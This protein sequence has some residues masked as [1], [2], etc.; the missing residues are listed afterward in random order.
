M[1]IIIPTEKRQHFILEGYEIY[2][3][4]R[5]N[6]SRWKK[7]SQKVSAELALEDENPIKY[8][9]SEATFL[10]AKWHDGDTNI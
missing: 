2:I 5:I 7:L 10:S 6:G 1:K 3:S 4:L 8:K 9:M